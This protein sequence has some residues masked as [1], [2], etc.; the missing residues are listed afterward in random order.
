MIAGGRAHLAVS[1]GLT[2]TVAGAGW[3]R[4]GE[5]PGHGAARAGCAGR[6]GPAP[7]ADGGGG[8]FPIQPDRH[9]AGHEQPTAPRPSA[10][11]PARARSWAAAAA[12]RPATPTRSAAGSGRLPAAAGGRSEPAARRSPLSWSTA[13][14]SAA[15]SSAA[16]GA[17][18]SGAAAFRDPTSTRITAAGRPTAPAGAFPAT[19]P[20]ALPATWSTSAGRGPATSS[21]AAAGGV[22]AVCSATRAGARGAAN[23]SL[24][25]APR[26]VRTS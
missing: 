6:G 13:S 22:R 9:N 24:R 16:P 23:G 14:G 17:A 25:A 19:A 12:P 21:A 8:L 4:S 2:R 20:G 26:G 11:G 5:L 10:S 15:W 3:W 18:A 1:D 7:W